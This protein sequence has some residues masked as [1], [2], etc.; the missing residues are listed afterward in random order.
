MQTRLGALVLA[1]VMI[2]GC[3]DETAARVSDAERRA[4]PTEQLTLGS[5]L[6]PEEWEARNLPQGDVRQRESR[7]HSQLAALE[8]AYAK[9]P[10]AVVQTTYLSSD[11]GPGE[12]Q[13][14]VRALARSHLVGITAEG[15]PRGR[16]LKRL[17]DR[18]RVLLDD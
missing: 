6:C 18:L 9:R 5:D 11:Q 14:T 8:A 3:G 13:L 7:G 17:E 4:L 1:A 15:I 10:D 16:C 12:E 2:A